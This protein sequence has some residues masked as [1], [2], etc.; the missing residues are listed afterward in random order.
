VLHTLGGMGVLQLLSPLLVQ[1]ARAEPEGAAAAAAA[2]AAAVAAGESEIKAFINKDYQFKV[3]V[4]SSELGACSG[5]RSGQR[6]PKRP[7]AGAGAQPG[8]PPVLLL[9]W[10]PHVLLVSSQDDLVLTHTPHTL[11]LSAVSGG[12][13]LRWL[14]PRDIPPRHV[15]PPSSLKLGASSGRRSGQRARKRPAGGAPGLAWLALHRQSLPRQPH[16]L[17]S[18]LT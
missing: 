2:A 4:L 13:P 16:L 1:G 17:T 18:V 7:A 15:T 8:P 14:V 9:P 6:A 3:G 5:R 12:K 10:Q 11:R